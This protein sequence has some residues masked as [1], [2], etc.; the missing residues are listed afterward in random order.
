MGFRTKEKEQAINLRKKGKSLS[1]IKKLVPVS[2]SSLSLWLR[3]VS[4]SPK[5]FKR[6]EKRSKEGHKNAVRTRHSKS[7]LQFDTH[8]C[9]ASEYIEGLVLDKNMKRLLAS[10]LYYCEGEKNL[11]S[12]VRFTNSDPQLVRLFLFLLRSSFLLDET[13]FRVCMHLHS[14]HDPER[15]AAFWS[16]ITRIPRN[17]FLKTFQKPNTGKTKKDGYN[18]C[19]SVR[20]NDSAITKQLIAHAEVFCTKG[21]IS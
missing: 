12:G 8:V 15:M 20:Y 18:G 6:L 3:G 19:V 11:H 9:E 21:P 13:K 4:L 16:R 5:A 10:L 17:Q 2:K 14:Y 7:R 1:E